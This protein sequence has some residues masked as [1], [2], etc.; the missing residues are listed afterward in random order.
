MSRGCDPKGFGTTGESVMNCL[1]DLSAR[2]SR[3][4][5]RACKTSLTEIQYFLA[6]DFQLNPRLYK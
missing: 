3:F 4:M 5:T 6:R 2:N 1:M